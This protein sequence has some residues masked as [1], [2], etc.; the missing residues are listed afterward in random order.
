[1]FAGYCTLLQTEGGFTAVY[2]IVVPQVVFRKPGFF[3]GFAQ[4][5]N[6]LAILSRIVQMNQQRVFPSSQCQRRPAM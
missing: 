3:T 5:A 6:T 1:M 4:K 2:R